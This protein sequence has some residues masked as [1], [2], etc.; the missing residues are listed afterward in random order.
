MH[1]F[2][3]LA[4]FVRLAERRGKNYFKAH[5]RDIVAASLEHIVERKKLRSAIKPT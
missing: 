4:H 3:E 5:V 2:I 1:T